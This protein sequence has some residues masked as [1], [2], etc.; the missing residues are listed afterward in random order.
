MQLAITQQVHMAHVTFYTVSMAP[1]TL[2]TPE[3]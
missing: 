3:L 1:L 2:V